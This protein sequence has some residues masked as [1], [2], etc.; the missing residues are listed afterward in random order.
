MH[1]RQLIRSPW[2]LG[3]R[4]LYVLYR[5]G[6]AQQTGQRLCAADLDAKLLEWAQRLLTVNLIYI[7]GSDYAYS[8]TDE[9]YEAFESLSAF[10][11]AGGQIL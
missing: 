8:L 1:Y 3:T 4:H 11:D 5:I 6:K 10:L 2:H 9:G 7:V